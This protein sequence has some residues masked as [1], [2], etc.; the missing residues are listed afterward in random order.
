[1]SSLNFCCR[2]YDKRIGQSTTLTGRSI[3][4]HMG[5]KLI[6]MFT[7]EYDHEGDTIIYGDT[8]S[9]ILLPF[10]PCQKERS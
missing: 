4:R 5:A 2:F 6:L 7:G 1:M 8:D 9:H 10:Q 3:T